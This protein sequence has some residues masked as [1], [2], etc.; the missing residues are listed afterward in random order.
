[1]PTIIADESEKLKR[2]RNDPAERRIEVLD[3]DTTRR[4]KVRA[5]CRVRVGLFLISMRVIQ[6]P[7]QGAW[8]SWPQSLHAE[9]GKWF[10]LV[11]CLSPT[12]KSKI[13][14]AVLN[15]WR[16]RLLFQGGER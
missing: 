8:V 13:D 14:E 6:Q 12:L 1:M 7:G 11:S 9:T 10:P 15:A 5:H 2:L 16:D 4:G 3:L